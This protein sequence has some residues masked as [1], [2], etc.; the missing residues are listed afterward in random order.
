M[1]QAI[2]VDEEA[3][4]A[5]R[6]AR[7]RLRFWPSRKPSTTT[8]RPNSTDQKN[9]P[10]SPTAPIDASLPWGSNKIDKPFE[11]YDED[12]DDFEEHP[13]TSAPAKKEP[14]EQSQP[15]AKSN[16]SIDNSTGENHPKPIPIGLD[17]GKI[18]EEISKNRQ[19][20]SSFRI[21]GKSTSTSSLSPRKTSSLSLKSSSILSPEATRLA[22]EAPERPKSAMVGGSME[23]NIVESGQVER[24]TASLD[25]GSNRPSST[26]SRFESQLET[27]TEITPTP[28]SQ[29][30]R[31]DPNQAAKDTLRRQWEN[32]MLTGNNTGAPFN[33]PW[34][35]NLADTRS[36]ITFGDATS[37]SFDIDRFRIN[38][39]SPPPVT[40]AD[41]TGVL[42]FG[43]VNGSTFAFGSSGPK[44]SSQSF[45]PLVSDAGISFGSDD[46][47][48]GDLSGGFHDPSIDGWNDRPRDIASEPTWL[49]AKPLSQ[50]KLKQKASN[51]LTV[52]EDPWKKASEKKNNFSNVW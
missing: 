51:D 22:A 26:L 50:G 30:L 3:A 1:S 10:K 20:P 32:P 46:G 12:A 44:V 41:T 38:T 31:D 47:S 33:D 2:D 28:Y 23:K 29:T 25:G 8:S 24:R 37:P 16:G 18:R 42:S 36:S 27:P 48:I 4:K 17:V 35:T 6:G 40:F 9:I 7:S 14:V 39:Y 52:E 19:Q 11:E 5:E 15:S 45:S 34:S 43:D 13:N 21:F 49:L